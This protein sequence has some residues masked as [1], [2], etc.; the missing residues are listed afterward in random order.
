MK[1]VAERYQKFHFQTSQEDEN[2]KIKTQK[3][4]KPKHCWW[5][6]CEE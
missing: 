1:R 4:W 6:I 5:Q 2:L 3:T